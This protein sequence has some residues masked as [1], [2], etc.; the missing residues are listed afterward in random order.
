MAEKLSARIHSGLATVKQWEADEE[1]LKECRDQIPFNLLCPDQF[2]HLNKK[3]EADES[4]YAKENDGEWKGDDLLLKR[5]TL[6]FKGIMTWVNNHPCELCGS[7]ETKCRNIRGP[8]SPAERA[9]QANRVEVYWCPTCNAETTLF[10]RY[11]QPRKIFETKKGRCGE[12]ANLFGLYCRAAGFETRYILDFTDHVWTEVYSNRLGRWIMCDGCEGVID[13]PAMYEKGWGKDLNCIL[14]FTT[15]SVVDVTRRYTRKF[16]S[17]EFQERRKAVCPAGEFQ[18][19]M[20]IAQF[21]ANLRHSERLSWKKIDELE[22][23][24]ATEKA[25]LE[26]A[27]T[28]NSWDGNDYSEGRQ[29]GSLEWRISRGEAGGS[30]GQT[31]SK[32][33]GGSS[34]TAIVH[35]SVDDV[36]D[37]SKLKLRCEDNTV[38]SSVSMRLPDTIMPL[39]SQENASIDD[40]KKAF[41]SFV[42]KEERKQNY[43]APFIGFCGFCT[44][45][46]SPVYLIKQ[47]AYP[48]QKNARGKG[49]EEYNWKT[50]HFVPDSLQSGIDDT[51]DSTNHIKDMEIDVV[52]TRL[53]NCQALTLE[54]QRKR[55]IEIF[56]KL[57]GEG[58]IANE[59]AAKAILQVAEE[60]QVIKG[61]YM[62][63]D[64]DAS[65][66]ESE[67]VVQ[68]VFD[69]KS[70]SPEVAKVVLKCIT[71]IEKNPFTPRFRMVKLSN[72]VFDQVT[73]SRGGLQLIVQYLGFDVFA[74]G[75]DFVAVVPLAA[76][77]PEMIKV[78]QDIM[79]D[80]KTNVDI[81]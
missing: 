76:N 77:I 15:D 10:P 26:Y 34:T 53:E 62:E 75:I 37:F 31:F 47:S 12:Y 74:V 59:A 16:K 65:N 1:L 14:A 29:S 57:C 42:N 72:R 81:F 18:A 25:F 48:F 4:P 79:E 9:G 49:S 7:T 54:E 80:C 70:I 19:E 27:E 61:A 67:V 33:K 45:Q 11:N 50:F 41:L 58:M 51:K 60:L 39:D 68:D 46:G 3:Q 71:N 21:N 24:I 55:V 78:A 64:G 5:L 56:T 13:E 17:A 40:K 28:M 73:S 22:R 6:Y 23:R 43:D 38:P 32:A 8:I 69:P 2:H 66:L 44:K 36:A 35:L 52:P 63:I 30:S 20:I